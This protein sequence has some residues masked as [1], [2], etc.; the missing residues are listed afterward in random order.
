MQKKI[1]QE[2]TLQQV[3]QTSPRA[4]KVIEKYFGKGCFGCPSFAV[5]PLFMGARQHSVDI[6]VL[7]DE[8]NATS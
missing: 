7:L 5:E 8:L 4:S 2:M 6:D 1:T 3:A